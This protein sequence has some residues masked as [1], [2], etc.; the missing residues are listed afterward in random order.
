MKLLVALAIVRGADATIAS[1]H[2][3]NYKQ[4]DGTVITLR[5][6]GDENFAYETDAKSGYPVVRADRGGGG[7]PT[8]VYAVSS[9][10]GE[11]SPTTLAVGA[12]ADPAVFGLSARVFK[13]APK[14]AEPAG[15]PRRTFASRGGANDLSVLA[16]L[17]IPIRFKGHEGR[18]VPSRDALDKLMN[19][20]GPHEEYCP[21]GSVRDVYRARAE[22]QPIR[23]TVQRTWVL[24]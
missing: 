4:P 16:Q 17:L 24:K 20:V 6:N 2:P 15:A 12:G 7:A 9:E 3:Y 22:S 13:P 1:P 21:T 10:A 23:D 14:Y 8:Y 11:L 19:H 5:M 18:D